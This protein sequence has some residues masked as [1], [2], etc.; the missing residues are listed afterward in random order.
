MVALATQK[1]EVGSLR[2]PGSL[3][4]PTSRIMLVRPANCGLVGNVSSGCSRSFWPQRSSVLK[5]LDGS[6]FLG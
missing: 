2:R 4:V 1:T 3:T 5:L 6:T